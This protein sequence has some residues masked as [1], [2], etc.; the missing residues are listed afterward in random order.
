MVLLLNFRSLSINN[1]AFLLTF[2]SVQH[3]GLIKIIRHPKKKL[4]S[5]GVF[6]MEMAD[7]ATADLL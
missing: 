3:I 4:K 6:K 5:V 1:Y 7:I 2:W